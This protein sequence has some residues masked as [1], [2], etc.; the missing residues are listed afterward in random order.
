MAYL[1][2]SLVRSGFMPHTLS[3]ALAAAVKFQC[4]GLATHHLPACISSAL[5]IF[6]LLRLLKTLSIYWKTRRSTSSGSM[7][8]TVR[9]LNLSITLAGMTVFAPGAEKA[10]SIPWT[11]SDG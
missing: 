4:F 5:Q 8:G 3:T 7:L 10:P 1:P 9:M 11:D 2:P 6:L